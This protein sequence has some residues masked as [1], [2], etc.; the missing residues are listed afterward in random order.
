MWFSLQVSRKIKAALP[1]RIEQPARRRLYLMLGSL[2]LTIALVALYVFSEQTFYWWDYTT[3][4]D[5]LEQ[6]YTELLRSP[7]EL[8]R[9]TWWS[10][11]QDYSD[12]PALLLLPFRLL[13]GRS[14]FSFILSIAIVYL[15]PLA[16]CLSAIARHLLPHRSK[17]VTGATLL[18]TVLTPAFWA[19]TLRGYV[20]AGGA[21]IVSVAVLVYLRD[22]SLNRRWQILALGLLLGF[23]PLFRRHFLYASIV[24]FEALLLHAVLDPAQRWKPDRRLAWHYTLLRLRRIGWVAL[25]S[26]AT[27]A[28]LGAPF[29]AR[30]TTVDFGALYAAYKVSVGESLRYYGLSYGW[31]LGVLSAIGYVLGYRLRLVDRAIASFL[32]LLYGIT[33]LLWLLQVRVVGVHYTSHLTP[34]V[35][36]GLVTLAVAIE[37]SDRRRLVAGLLAAYLG[38]NALLSFLPLR[39]L[40]TTPLRATQFGITIQPI[41]QGTLLSE[42]FSASYAPLQRAD[43]AELKRLVKTLKSLTPKREPIYVGGASSLFN[44]SLLK[45]A[46]PTNALRILPAEDIDSRDQYPLERL[47]QA[48]YVVVATPFQHDIQPQDQEVVKVV[49]DLFRQ[50]WQLAQDFRALPPVF[51]LDQDVTVQI[52]QRVRET[53]LSTIASTLETMKTAI[54]NRPGGQLDW[55]AIDHDPSFFVWRGRNGYYIYPK[56]EAN[57]GKGAFLYLDPPSPNQSVLSARVDY[58]SRNCPGVELRLSAIDAAG[59]PR[60]R[61]K[62]VFMSGDAPNLSLSVATEGSA[63]LLLDFSSLDHLHTQR[64]LVKFRDGEHCQLRLS[65]LKMSS[66]P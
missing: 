55:I 11:N 28:L 21:L 29:L 27:I 53:A 20:D 63:W 22:R 13:L 43:Y 26:L 6:K 10:T 17:F 30:L 51:S 1:E 18:I 33:A 57:T 39:L 19:S 65:H 34:L 2:A 4:S 62:Q 35:S 3:Y 25:A 44:A 37:R 52:Y 61:T 38:L 60:H 16:F 42:L 48:Q 5:I 40:A 9:Q 46:D 47:L 24:F 56:L 59:Q 7:L 64:D 36:L 49:T 50:R 32:L 66:E 12:Y 41:Q 8:L 58:P 54:G 31:V 14:R 15:L 23:L 45:N